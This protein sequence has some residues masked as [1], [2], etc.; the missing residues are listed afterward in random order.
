LQFADL[1]S[2]LPACLPCHRQ[3]SH[4]MPQRGRVEGETEGKATRFGLQGLKASGGTQQQ[5][6]SQHGYAFESCLLGYM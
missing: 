3:E 2:L 4:R 1:T 5:S 6:L